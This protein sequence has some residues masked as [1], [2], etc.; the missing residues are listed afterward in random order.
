MQLRRMRKPPAW[1]PAPARLQ[2]ELRCW[3]RNLAPQLQPGVLQRL[4]RAR[5]Q[6]LGQQ[7]PGT[8]RLLRQMTPKGPE[9]AQQLPGKGRLP[10]QRML[11]ERGRAQRPRMRMRQGTAAEEKSGA[12]GWCWR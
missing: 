3:L 9:Q 7:L 5:E 4:L 8:G 2:A 12:A 6:G 11:K 10:Q 1:V